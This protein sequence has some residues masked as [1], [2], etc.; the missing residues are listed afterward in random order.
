M[1]TTTVALIGLLSGMAGALIVEG[2]KLAY[3]RWQE[4]LLPWSHS[5]GSASPPAPGS[6]MADW[7]PLVDSDRL[8]ARPLAP[9]STATPAP[10]PIPA[11]GPVPARTASPEGQPA[12]T[13][14]PGERPFPVPVNPA[15]AESD[16]R[17]A[18]SP[19]LPAPGEE[20]RDR[21]PVMVYSQ[22]SSILSAL[23]NSAEVEAVLRASRGR[24]GRDG[25]NRGAPPPIPRVSTPPAA[26]AAAAG[27]PA[28]PRPEIRK[29]LEDE[30]SD[31]PGGL[32]I[33]AVYLVLGGSIILALVFLFLALQPLLGR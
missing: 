28:V 4:G 19:A 23:E 15:I 11:G 14:V 27:T 20:Q 8:P 9:P 21:T 32:P 22:E 17:P 16:L 31:M 25:P 10:A 33:W 29:T 7:G 1:S 5:I 2:L 26:P 30:V 13:P 3:R 6:E 18:A 12:R 24:P